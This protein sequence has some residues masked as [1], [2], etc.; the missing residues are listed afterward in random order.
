MKNPKGLPEPL[1]SCTGCGKSVHT[2][3][4][5]TASKT[6]QQIQLINLVANGS[7]WYCDDCKSCDGCSK[8]QAG[9]CLMDCCGCHK[10]FH[11]ACLDP[12]PEKKVKCAWRWVATVIKCGQ[13]F[14]LGIFGFLL[15]V[16]I[17]CNSMIKLKRS[18]EEGSLRMFCR[19]KHQSLLLLRR[20]KRWRKKQRKNRRIKGRGKLF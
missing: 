7:K 6:S 5:N 19:L 1:S 3:C 9:F 17:V 4:A 11:L 14:I 8:K 15:G 13:N 10:N 16:D 12:V 20:K 2:S 18:R